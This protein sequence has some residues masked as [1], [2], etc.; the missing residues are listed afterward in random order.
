MFIDLAF[1]NWLRNL[2]GEAN[3]QCLDPGANYKQISSHPFEGTQMR[4]LM[5]GFN[6]LKEHFRPDGRDSLLDLP[7][8][9]DGLNLDNK[10]RDGEVVIP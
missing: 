4:E 2:L 9:L 7:R 5:K 10:I 1:K 3:Y 8:P 6:L